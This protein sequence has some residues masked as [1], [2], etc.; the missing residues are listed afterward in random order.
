MSGFELV[1]GRPPRTSFDWDTPEAATVQ[2]RLNQDKAKAIA[3]RMYEA[4]NKAKSI[5][6]KAQEKKNKDVNAHRQ[7]V[8]F[9]EGDKVWV[10]IKNWRT[11]RPSHKLDHQM[12]G[13]FEIIQ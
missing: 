3:T 9:G 7:E 12:A 8:N 11:Q 6:A 5:M 4:I 1:N 2:E 10:S 13:P